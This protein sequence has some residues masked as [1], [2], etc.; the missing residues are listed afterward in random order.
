MFV[1]DG[2]LVTTAKEDP[3]SHKILLPDNGLFFLRAVHSKKGGQPRLPPPPPTLLPQY[4]G[5]F[6]NRVETKISFLSSGIWKNCLEI[7]AKRNENNS[8]KMLTYREKKYAKN[9]DSFTKI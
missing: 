8:R 4:G 3:R 6:L 9:A 2:E 5:A 7:W 1:Q